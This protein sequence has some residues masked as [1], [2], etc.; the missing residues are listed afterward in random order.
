M[1]SEKFC[2]KWNDFESNI[3]SAFQDIRHEKD[4]FDVTVAC[5]EEQ[6]Q[7]HKVILSACSPFFKSV[8][9][10]NQHQHPLLYLRGVSFR[11]LESVLNFMYH[12]EVNVA[13][14]DLNSFLQVAED[15]KVK[16]LTQNNSSTK[17]GSQSVSH[18]KQTVLKSEVKTDPPRPRH[19]EHD[20]SHSLKRPH[21][22][23]PPTVAPRSSYVHTP[24]PQAD[25]IEVIVP[26]KSEPRDTVQ[27]VQTM[28]QQDQAMAMYDISQQ[29]DSA[30]EQYDDNYGVD[31]DGQYVDQGYDGGMANQGGGQD[32]V[33]TGRINWCDVCSKTVV[34][35][36]RHM[37][38]VHGT[39]NEVLCDI[40]QK[41]FKNDSSCKKHMRTYHNIY[42]KA[43]NA[44]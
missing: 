39:N 37:N 41:I 22:T 43:D 2:L 42:L 14:D 18:N 21:Q 12:G 28:V 8:L 5:D 9:R 15:L 1:A 35:Y 40:C 23:P 29:Q 36:K 16:G 24:T 3:S 13:Q 4:F 44:F 19:Q 10:R 17:S 31:F 11:D 33:G 30:M 6:L 25:D 7:A 38:D 34:N 27:S 26:V 32:N 20:I